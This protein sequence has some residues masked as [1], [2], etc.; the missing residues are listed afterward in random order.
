MPD[1]SS[2]LT[3]HESN[4]SANT[5]VEPINSPTAK[6]G[7][8]RTSVE[9]F[10]LGGDLDLE[11]RLQGDAKQQGEGKAEGDAPVVSTGADTLAHDDPESTSPLPV[12]VPRKLR[13]D[14][15][16]LQTLARPGPTRRNG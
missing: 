12:C 16:L 6:A 14:T 4:G 15:S 11:K 7:M 5:I 10:D 8:R 2:Q 1:T 9:S 3:V 13:A